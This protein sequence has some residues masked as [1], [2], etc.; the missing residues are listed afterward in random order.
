[1]WNTIISV[2]SRLHYTTKKLPRGLCHVQSK[3]VC[4]R[5]RINF[6]KKNCFL[7][8]CED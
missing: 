1:M 6:I 5:P 7:F 3:P 2:M 8:I 4:L